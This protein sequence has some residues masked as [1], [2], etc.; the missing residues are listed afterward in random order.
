MRVRINL[1]KNWGKYS[2]SIHAKH[3]RSVEG[4]NRFY[5]DE[6]KRGEAKT[7]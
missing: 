4:C 2:A 7:W 3:A 1:L 5:V 6:Q